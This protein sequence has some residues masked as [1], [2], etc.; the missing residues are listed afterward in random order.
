MKTLKKYWYFVVLGIFIIIFLITKIFSLSKPLDKLKS[1]LIENGFTSN[2]QAT[3]LQK[4]SSISEEEYDDLE[5]GVYKIEAFNYEQNKFSY[6]TKEKIAQKEN[7]YMITIDILKGEAVGIRTL[8]NDYDEEWNIKGTYNLKTNEYICDTNG[9]KGLTEYC[10]DIKKKINEYD[11]QV[12]DYLTESKT[13]NYYFKK[14][15]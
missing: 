8:Y 5:S 1:Y 2:Y 11:L 14:M 7:V 10:D 4:L 13:S 9:Y 15:Y 3:E 12:E 6:I